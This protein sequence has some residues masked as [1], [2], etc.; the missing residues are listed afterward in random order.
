MN[1][2][3]PRRSRP[4]GRAPARSRARPP[5]SSRKRTAPIGPSS[6]GGGGGADAGAVDV[7]LDRPVGDVHRAP[8]RDRRPDHQPV[9]VAEIGDRDRRTEIVDRR[10]R[11][12]RDLDPDMHRVDQRRGLGIGE[13][14]LARGRGGGDAQ[15][16]IRPRRRRTRART[17]ASRPR[18]RCR[19]RCA[20]RRSA[21]SAG[22]RRRSA[23]RSARPSSRRWRCRRARSPRPG[24][25]SRR[26]APAAAAPD[27]RATP[28]PRGAPRQSSRRSDAPHR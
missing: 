11:R 25:H 7:K 8:I 21:R 24:P 5:A 28:F 17:P 12:A 1:P 15:Q 4:I 22:R 6:I 18:P 9:V 2:G 19:R 14:R 27:I 16:G 26:R 10:E 20:R 23:D 13:A 3:G